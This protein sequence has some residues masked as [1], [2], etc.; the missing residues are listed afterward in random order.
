M[1]DNIIIGFSTAKAK[2]APIAVAIRAVERTPYSHVYLKFY[3]ASIDRWLIYHASHT[4]VH[5]NNIET[6]NE[7]NKILEE[8]EMFSTPED[9]REALQLCVDRV[10]LPYGRRQLIGMAYVRLVKAWFGRK[11]SN[12]F[13]D[14][15]RTQVCSEIAG[16][17]IRI[18]KGPIDVS[19]LEYEGPRYIHDVVLE[20]VRD[21]QAKRV[22]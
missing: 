3:S 14:G 7:E 15:K 8:Y 12:P 18:L 16:R 1:S 21:G 17:I 9:R 22:K 19:L 11:I 20:M 2:N 6:F 10:G 4:N 13:A 5:F